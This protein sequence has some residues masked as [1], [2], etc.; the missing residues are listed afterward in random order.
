MDKSFTIINSLLGKPR[1]SNKEVENLSNKTNLSSEVI[2]V[3]IDKEC[4]NIETKLCLPSK[5]QR[6][7]EYLTTSY[8]FDENIISSYQLYDVPRVHLFNLVPK[9]D[10]Y[11]KTVKVKSR[12][13][14]ISQMELTEENVVSQNM[15]L[16]SVNNLSK[17]S[18][19]IN[20]VLTMA[21]TTINNKQANP[22]NGD[23]S[24]KINNHNILIAKNGHVVEQ[25]DNLEPV[26][27]KRGRPKKIV[28]NNDDETS[29]NSAA[30]K[31]DSFL[32][33]SLTDLKPEYSR[34]STIV[35]RGRVGKKKNLIIPT[36][37]QPQQDVSN[38]TTLKKKKKKKPIVISKKE[39]LIKK[40]NIVLRNNVNL[41][42]SANSG[43]MKLNENLYNINGTDIILSN[44]CVTLE[45]YDSPECMSNQ[46]TILESRSKEENELFSEFINVNWNIVPKR[47]RS[48]SVDVPSK[49]RH[50]RN[51]LF[52]NFVYSSV[53][54]SKIYY[55]DEKLMRTWKSH[56][57]L[58]SGPNIHLGSYQRNEVDKTYKLKVR[59]SRSFPNCMLLDTV[60]WRFL[61]YQ[62]THPDPDD[63][64]FFSSGSETDL[65]NE[66]LVSK[67]NRQNRSKSEPTEQYKSKKQK[68]NYL[69]RSIDNLNM[70][71]FTNN[72]LSSP[73]QI[74][75]DLCDMKNTESDSKE[76]EGKIR[77]SKRLN[78]KIKHSD[79]LE[80]EYM[81]DHD[82]SELDYLL[83][84]EQIR[85]ENY[86]QLSEARKN[87]PE[88]ENK[89]KKLNF[90]LVTNNIFR[91]H[92]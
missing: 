10:D 2:S 92:R 84:A 26:K 31:K 57:Y 66:V 18:D 8:I 56:S 15:N 79:M 91:P 75:A 17:S 5:K 64:Y 85:K 44:V 49:I 24:I 78:T 73:L 89:L 69:F 12:W 67:Y 19:I 87:D 63:N 81:L 82:E 9:I 45:R 62:Q 1:Y 90:T 55:E 53:G 20:Q 60:T 71:C 43:E 23:K 28:V 3:S 33:N 16:S 27:R 29:I 6:L 37:V 51:S 34:T 13:T 38:I 21:V 76:C 32:S 86:K 41:K 77:R 36:I 70:L 42:C 40:K 54:S 35:T 46:S 50:R 25:S 48:K 88:L 39:C 22:N 58:E 52:D 4:F 14:H 11:K 59:R 74:T 65:L 72:L 68:N 80:E 83:L 30:V 61:V 47:I 7:K